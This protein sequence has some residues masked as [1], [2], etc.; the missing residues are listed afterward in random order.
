MQGLNLQ[1]ERPHLVDGFGIGWNRFW[2]PVQL[3]HGAATPEAMAPQEI[4][5]VSAT[6]AIYRTA[7]LRDAVL[8][9]GDV[10]DARLESYYEDVDLAIRLRRRGWQARALPSARALHAGAE[11]SRDRRARFQWLA[12]SNRLLVSA[13]LFGRSLWRALPLILIRD[14]VEVVDE[15]AHGRLAEARASLAGW[16]RALRLLGEFAHPGP[17]AIARRELQRFRVRSAAAALERA[18]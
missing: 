12:F 9:S 16:L 10:F 18:R 15:I 14:V 6:A 1:L 7:A 11:S 5:G 3:G 17:R 8:D 13:R 2:R 4:F